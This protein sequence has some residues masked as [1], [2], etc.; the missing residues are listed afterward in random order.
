MTADP[1]Q[2]SLAQAAWAQHQ[3]LQRYLQARRQQ[4]TEEELAACERELLAAE[5]R[6]RE[7]RAAFQF[8]R[9]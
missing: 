9:F 4:A 8:G 3:Q 2:V 7:A 5:Q 6:C 1:A